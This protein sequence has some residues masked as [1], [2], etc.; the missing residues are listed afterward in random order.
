[1][2]T[3]RQSCLNSIPS[4]SKKA[5]ELLATYDLVP[6]PKI[7]EVDLR[8][9]FAFC[10]SVAQNQLIIFTEDGDL[11]KLILSRL[12][13]HSTFPNIVLRGKSLGGSDDVQSLH[14]EK[15]LKPIFEQ[16]GVHVM[17]DVIG[18]EV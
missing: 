5:K 4:Y 1:M 11:I 8:G 17:G 13:T 15:K 18:I 3:D 6:P 16:G 12:T 7:V 14:D 10:D 2:P 9:N